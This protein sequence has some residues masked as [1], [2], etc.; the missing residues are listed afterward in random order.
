MSSQ[1]S[2]ACTAHSSIEYLPQHYHGG[3]HWGQHVP[4][5]TPAPA[6]APTHNA[7]ANVHVSRMMPKVDLGG[8]RLQHHPP[9]SPLSRHWLPGAVCT[10]CQGCN[11]TR[12]PS[13]PWRKEPSSIRPAPVSPLTEVTLQ[14]LPTDTVLNIRSSDNQV[15]EVYFIGR[16]VMTPIVPPARSACV[17][18]EAVRG[19]RPPRR[20]MTEVC[21][22]TSGLAVESPVCT[23]VG[24]AV[25]TN[26]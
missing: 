12:W 26:A 14:L 10:C 9:P 18:L 23:R 6:P 4:V 8:R 21:S 13:A 17:A 2:E 7:M 22:A 16:V 5:P 3:V 25:P 20:P 1:S 24:R 15:A 11:C 19:P